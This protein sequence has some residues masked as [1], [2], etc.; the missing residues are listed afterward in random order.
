MTIVQ[1]RVFYGKIGTGEQLIK[2]L[3]EGNEAFLR[4][5]PSLKSRVLSDHN[6]GR[7]DRVAAEWEMENISDFDAALEKAMADPQV[8]AEFGPW[9]DK[10]NGL[11]HHAEVEHWHVH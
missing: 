8:Q 3:Q 6:S 1:R 9:V 7:T 2:H 4:Y 11:I 5:A 10:L